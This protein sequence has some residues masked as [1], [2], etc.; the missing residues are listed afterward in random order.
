MSTN[1]QHATKNVYW[2]RELPPL[3]ADLMGEHVIE[4]VS[5]R[6][7]S[8]LSHRDEVWD[9]CYAELMNAVQVRL[10]QEIVRL[11][12]D[13]AHV[14]REAID[15][16]HDERSGETWLRGRFTYMLYRLPHVNAEGAHQNDVSRATPMAS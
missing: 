4:A 10:T 3:C 15:T 13:C 9:R 8:T 12:G 7:P 2:H 14:L 1:A 11:G 16:R 5:G 6:V